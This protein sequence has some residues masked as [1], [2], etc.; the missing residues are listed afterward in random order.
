MENIINIEGKVCIITG[1]G[2]GI[3]YETAIA[4]K[5]QG[6]RLG[7]ITRNEADLNKLLKV[8]NADDLPPQ[9]LC[10][11]FKIS[12]IEHPKKPSSYSGL[13]LYF[14]GDL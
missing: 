9:N 7:L 13:I 12:Y 8:L 3:G 1:V 14:L 4:F 6:A 5:N 2:K 11:L 10:Q